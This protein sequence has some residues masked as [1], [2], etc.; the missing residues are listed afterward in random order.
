MEAQKGGVMCIVVQL[1]LTFVSLWTSLQGPSVHGN[2]QAKVL[3]WISISLSME[4]FLDQ[5]LNPCP[6]HWQADCLPLS[7]QGSPRILKQVAYPFSRVTCQPRNRTSVPCIARRLTAQLSQEA[8][9]CVY[10]YTHT[11]IHTYKHAANLCCR[12]VETNTTL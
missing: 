1:C 8:H 10:V 7:H 6:L 4:I 2:S 5:G 9:M 12:I 11:H 3:A